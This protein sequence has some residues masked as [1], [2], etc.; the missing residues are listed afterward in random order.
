M[1]T[2]TRTKPRSDFPLLAHRNGQWA[3]K[4][5][6]TLRYFGAWNDPAAA[7]A[8]YVGSTTTSKVTSG[9]KPPKPSKV[10]PL[11]AHDA[12]QWANKVRGKLH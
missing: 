5:N 10:F 4:V 3:K 1:T 6:G 8:R 12:G 2:P 9:E 7:E 11:F